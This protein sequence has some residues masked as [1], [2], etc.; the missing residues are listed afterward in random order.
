[1]ERKGLVVDGGEKAG[2]YGIIAFV[3]TVSGSSARDSATME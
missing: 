2:W 3:D 1:M